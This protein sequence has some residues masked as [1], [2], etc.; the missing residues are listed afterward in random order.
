MSSSDSEGDKL[1]EG[2]T[3]PICLDTC[4]DA[5]HCSQCQNVFCLECTSSIPTCPVCRAKRNF[6]PSLLARRLIGS[7]PQTCSH[8]GCHAIMKQDALGS[9]ELFCEHRL[10]TCP[11]PHCDYE[12]KRDLFLEHLATIHMEVLLKKMDVLF[13]EEKEAKVAIRERSIIGAQIGSNGREARLGETG[14][15]YCGGRLEEHCSCC[16]GSCGPGNGCNC[17]SCMKLDVESRLLPRGYLVNRDGFPSRKGTTGHWYCGRQVMEREH[18]CDGFCGPTNGPN[19]RACR[20][21]ER[22]VSSRYSSLL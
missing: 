9:H 20:K 4:K 17:M 11:H 7:I 8:E 1:E 10:I 3:C 15:Y 22:Q 18:R 12:G 2:L 21:L 13:L 16:D 14:K 5:V 6:V 19:C